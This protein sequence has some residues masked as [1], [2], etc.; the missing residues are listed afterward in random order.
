M[1]QE[2]YDKLYVW[3]I[4]VGDVDN[5]AEALTGN[6]HLKNEFEPNEENVTF[7]RGQY[8][9]KT[10]LVKDTMKEAFSILAELR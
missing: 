1:R 7:Y 8:E 10:H 3:G 2:S 4:C 5:I 9:K 6:I